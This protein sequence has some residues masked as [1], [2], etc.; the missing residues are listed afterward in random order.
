MY[1]YESISDFT[2][3]IVRKLLRQNIEIENLKFFLQNN[4]FFIF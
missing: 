4:K 3:H 2:C 1:T